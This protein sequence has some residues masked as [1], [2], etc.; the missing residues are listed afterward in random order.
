MDR[1]GTLN[2]KFELLCTHLLVFVKTIDLIIK[3][4]V[5]NLTKHLQ[6]FFL[7]YS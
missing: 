2:Q 7:E 1:I 5:N 4:I 3:A 6:I